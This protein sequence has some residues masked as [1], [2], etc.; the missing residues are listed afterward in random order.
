M[1]FCWRL[2]THHA[3]VGLPSPPPPSP[4]SKGACA[5]EGWGPEVSR[6]LV[7]DAEGRGSSVRPTRGRGELELFSHFG[8][9][10]RKPW[11]CRIL[12]YAEEGPGWSIKISSS[13][14]RATKKA[15]N[16]QSGSLGLRCRVCLYPPLY[17]LLRVFW[18]ILG[19]LYFPNSYVLGLPTF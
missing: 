4:P 19:Y 6:G 18:D 12:G 14:R 16:F 2:G 8:P 17:C 13:A 5:S 7:C 9:S 11:E 15:P 10:A 1:F 3:P